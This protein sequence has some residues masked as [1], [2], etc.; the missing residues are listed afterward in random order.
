MASP[1]SLSHCRFQATQ[2]KGPV[3]ITAVLPALV[4]LFLRKV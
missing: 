1:P 4:A 2:M 3:P